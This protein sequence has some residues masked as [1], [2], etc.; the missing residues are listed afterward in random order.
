MSKPRL[1]EATMADELGAVAS[2]ARSHPPAPPS[3]TV[4][5]PSI[6]VDEPSRETSPVPHRELTRQSTSRS[7]ERPS[8][9]IVGRPKAFY[10]TERLN[11]RLDQ[12]VRYYQEVHGLAKIDRS[13]VVNAMLDN[14]AL[15]TDEALDSQIDRMIS[16]LTSRLTG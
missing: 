15:W 14:R 12:A 16:Q 2:F 8:G 13:T 11:Q 7:T 9:R 10:I 6:P 4:T 3:T 1:D 5:V